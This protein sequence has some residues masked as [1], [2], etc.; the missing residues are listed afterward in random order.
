MKRIP[1]LLV[2]LT[3][4]VSLHLKAQKNL[5]SQDSIKVFYDELFSALKKGCLHR[6]IVDWKEVEPQFRNRLLHYNSFQKSLEQIKP[7]FDEIEANH[8]QVYVNKIKYAGTGKS[9]T[10]DEYS[11][12]L[13]NKYQSKPSFEA[14]VLASKY[15]YVLIPAM[16]FFDTSPAYIH[17]LAQPL[18]D[19][20]A[21]IKTKNKLDGWI[22]DL[23][24]N[25]GGNATPMLLSLYDLLGDN[26]I[27]GS[28]NSNKKQ[29][30][31][32]SLS[33]G[34]YIDGAKNPAYIITKGEL[35][36]KERVAVI[37]GIFTGSSGEVT[38]LAFKGRANTIFIGENT[39]GATTGNIFWPLP[40]KV[41]I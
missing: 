1:L 22:V 38:A 14:K 24:V 27:W 15:G 8:C 2:I 37:T 6:K 19:Q 41:N 12:Q 40:Q 30:E 23:R 31:K 17:S 28:L 35:L 21:D 10:K 9:I 25:S 13:K 39:Y 11:E 26:Q 3:L 4:G 7:L 5:S 34:K 32:F 36:D 16:T 20:I 29:V 18:Y 33:K